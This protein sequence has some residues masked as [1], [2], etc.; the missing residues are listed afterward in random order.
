MQ[1]PLVAEQWGTL[2]AAL[3]AFVDLPTLAAAQGTAPVAASLFDLLLGALNIGH[4]T[5]WRYAISL[6][7][8]LQALLPTSSPM[9][10][11]LSTR[12]LSVLLGQLRQLP[13]NLTAEQTELARQACTLLIP[14]LIPETALALALPD[15]ITTVNS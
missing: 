8:H 7:R 5:H 12:T 1:R 3:W 11:A 15:I 9:H 6:M 14:L 2:F 13:A 10:T 4:A